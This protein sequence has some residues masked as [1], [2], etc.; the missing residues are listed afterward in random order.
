MPFAIAACIDRH[1]KRLALVRLEQLAPLVNGE[2]GKTSIDVQLPAILA[3]DGDIDAVGASHFEVERSNT[4]R[5]AN[6]GIV[7]IYRRERRLSNRVLRTIATS[8]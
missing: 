3:S 2:I 1:R 5:D 8:P 4:H 7:G 6:V